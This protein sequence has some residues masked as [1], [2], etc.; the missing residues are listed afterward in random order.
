MAQQKQ[1]ILL[2]EDDK[3]LGL[4]YLKLLEK[5]GFVVH[6]ALDGLFALKWLEENTPDVII[7]DIMMPRLDGH[8]L[9]RA[10][11]YLEGKHYLPSIPKIILTAKTDARSVVQGINLGCKF[12]L[13]KP[14]NS[15]QLEDKIRKALSK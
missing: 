3:P 6:L 9:L 11:Q 13:Q 4:V 1:L 7:T 10:L 14:C 15:I 5:M 2:V 12:F 8:Q